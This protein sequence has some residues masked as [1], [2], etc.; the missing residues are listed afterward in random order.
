LTQRGRTPLERGA[1]VIRD[2]LAKIGLIVD[3]VA[4]DGAAVIQKFVSGRDYD[5]V[6]FSFFT[7]DTDPAINADFWFS[8]GSAHVWNIGQTTPATEWERQI[9]EVMRRQIGAADEVERKRLFD[10]VQAI[11]AA[12]LPIV[13][14]VAPKVYAASA[15]RVVN[16]TPALSRPQLLWSPDSIAVRRGTSNQSDKY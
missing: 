16:V 7:S 3:V 14:F 6:Y 10:Q 8:A 15:S 1:A 9:D 12:H 4:L 11:F 5:A 13:N 2:E